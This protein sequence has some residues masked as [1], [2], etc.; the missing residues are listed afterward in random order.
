[1]GKWRLENI[2]EPRVE[3]MAGTLCGHHVIATF[4]LR[5]TPGFFSFEET[6][7]LDWHERITVIEHHN[8]TYWQ[9]TANQY[10]RHP[11]A[12]TMEPWARRYVDAYRSVMGPDPEEDTGPNKKPPPPPPPPQTRLL[13]MRG[14]P[15]TPD[16]L[17]PAPK[18]WLAREK[19][20][21]VQA[22]LKKRGGIF[23]TTIHDKPEILKTPNPVWRE[24]LLEFD[25]GVVGNRK[26]RWRLCQYLEYDSTQPELRLTRISQPEWPPLNTAGLT[27][28]PPNAAA[29]LQHSTEDFKNCPEGV[30]YVL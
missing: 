24:R 16:V 20:E 5:Y 29:A 14:V 30:G 23:E 15:L 4:T 27:R 3:L 2:T 10:L 11:T 9:L 8:R 26:L 13:D 18:R 22:Y 7:L 17:T 12:I 6:P 1:M 25:I 19:R 21:S 28:V